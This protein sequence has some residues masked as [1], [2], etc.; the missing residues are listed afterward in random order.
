MSHKRGLETSSGH[1]GDVISSGCPRDVSGVHGN[2][3]GIVSDGNQKGMGPG[4]K[5]RMKG[6]K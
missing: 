2:N 5:L 4:K 6:S 1:A 3:K